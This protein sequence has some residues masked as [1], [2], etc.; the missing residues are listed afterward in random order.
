VASF[1]FAALAVFGAVERAAAMLGAG[2]LP[3]EWRAALAAAGL[4]ALALADLRAMQRSTYCPIGWRRQTPRGLMRRHHML[5]V[6][7][8]W[9]F[10]TGLIVTTFRVAAV[11]WGA[12]YL[13]ALG[14]SPR[15]A[16]A[17]YGAAFVVPF[18]GLLVRPGLG[19]AAKGNAATDPGLEPMLH[20]RFRVQGVSAVL[21]TATGV[22][23]ALRFIVPSWFRP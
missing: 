20:M 19:R 22:L 14:M 4:M 10:D 23:F 6:A 16:G 21:L 3:L 12:L 7:S 13:A 17:A 18:T 15:W 2:R 9:G 5:V 11:S 8:L 1:L